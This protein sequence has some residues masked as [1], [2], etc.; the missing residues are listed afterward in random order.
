MPLYRS[1]NFTDMEDEIYRFETGRTPNEILASLNN[2]SHVYFR[3]LSDL[4][5]SSQ[6]PG[7][8]LKDTVYM[9]LEPFLT[10]FIDYWCEFDLDHASPSLLEWDVPLSQSFM[11]FPDEIK[12]HII[13]TIPCTNLLT[14]HVVN[15]RL[16]EL[17]TPITHSQLHFRMLPGSAAFADSSI[18]PHKWASSAE[19]LG[20]IFISQAWFPI[21]SVTY[22]SWPI[23]NHC[24]FK[25][26]HNATVTRVTITGYRHTDYFIP[27]VPFL[28]MLLL[29]SVGSAFSWNPAG[30][31]GV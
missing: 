4:V 15:K 5:A 21:V 12:M 14:L 16:W 3:Y 22:S 7:S 8:I 2:G 19:L 18:T 24:F 23:R 26:L 10:S 28:F 1:F 27:M 31:V 11:D 29:T 30:F 17:I 13:G 9:S 6:L 25:F 20:A